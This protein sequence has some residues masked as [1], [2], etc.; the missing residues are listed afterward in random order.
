MLAITKTTN[1]LRTNV[2][3]MKNEDEIRKS[4][5]WPARRSLTQ[6]HASNG[7]HDPQCVSSSFN[8]ILPHIGLMRSAFANCLARSLARSR[9]LA[10]L[11]HSS[12]WPQWLVSCESR[13]IEMENRFHNR[14]EV[15]R[16]S[17]V[18]FSLFF[19]PLR[20]QFISFFMFSVSI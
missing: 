4:V 20:F 8:S 11:L 19:L 17:F 3:M 1:G 13:Y 9:L 16:L 5:N 6:T 7:G 2:D 10:R 12:M 15:L 18:F 14:E